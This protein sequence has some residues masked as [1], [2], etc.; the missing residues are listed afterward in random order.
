V[1]EERADRLDRL[2][3]IAPELRGAVTEDV[4]PGRLEPCCDEIAAETSVER[5]RGEILRAGYRG[6]GG[7]RGRRELPRPAWEA[8][9]RT[10]DD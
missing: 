6:N 8:I 2:P 3:G 10:L 7:K 1:I 5:A 4:K 9:R